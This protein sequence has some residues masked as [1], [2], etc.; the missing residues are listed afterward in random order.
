AERRAAQ[1][2]AEQAAAAERRRER[3]AAREDARAV[4]PELL[5]ASAAELPSARQ[6]VIEAGG[7]PALAAAQERLAAL[8]RPLATADPDGYRDELLATLEALVSLRWRLGDPEGS[9]EAARERK[10]W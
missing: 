5:Q 2:L 1:E 4:Q 10:S 9:R 7:E 3:A 8:L 6:Q